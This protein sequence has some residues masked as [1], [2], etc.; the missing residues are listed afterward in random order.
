MP[1]TEATAVNDIVQNPFPQG[2]AV[3]REDTASRQDKVKCTF[4]A[5]ELLGKGL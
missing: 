4:G 5:T 1:D 2:A 3:L